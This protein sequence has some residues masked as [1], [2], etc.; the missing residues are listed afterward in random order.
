MD[1]LTSL[2]ETKREMARLKQEL[3]ACRQAMGA[4]QRNESKYRHLVENANEAVLVAQDG[5]FRYA[6]PKAEDLFG[7]SQQE[8][9]RQPLT[10]FVHPDDREIVGRQNESG[11]RAEDGAEGTTFRIVFFPATEE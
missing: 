4:L 11:R 5:F 10:T 2:Q 7:Y 1:V 9:S 3:H 8:L 6:N